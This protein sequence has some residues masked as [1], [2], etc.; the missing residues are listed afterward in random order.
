MFNSIYLVQLCVRHG[1]VGCL[2]LL[3]IKTYWETTNWKTDCIPREEK[4]EWTFQVLNA[5]NFQA[6]SGSRADSDLLSLLQ[7]YVRFFRNYAGVWEPVC[8]CCIYSN[9]HVY[10][11]PN[12][13]TK[14]VNTSGSCLFLMFCIHFSRP[15]ICRMFFL[16]LSVSVDSSRFQEGL[17]TKPLT[18][19]I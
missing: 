7:S 1:L 5:L 12:L 19:S 15:V 8:S 10:T 2:S 4:G 3:F 16:V 18:G 11:L 13:W 6:G 14:T 9:V 17:P